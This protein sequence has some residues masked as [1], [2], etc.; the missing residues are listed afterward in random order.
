MDSQVES[1][2]VHLNDHNLEEW[3]ELQTDMNIDQKT[4]LLKLYMEWKHLQVEYRK[5]EFHHHLSSG[6]T[7]STRQG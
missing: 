2:I 4:T 3:V 1:Y 5:A 7:S 6:H